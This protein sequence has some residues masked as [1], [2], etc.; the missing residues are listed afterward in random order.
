[1]GGSINWRHLLTFAL[2]VSCSAAP[3]NGQGLTVTSKS[4]PIYLAGNGAIFY[5]GPV[6]QTD[7]WY[8]WN[9]GVYADIWTSASFNQK[10]NFGKELDLTVGRVGKLGTFSYSANINYYVVIVTDVAGVNAELS[11]GFSRGAVSIEPYV[12]GEW[13]FPVRHGG[14]RRGVLGIGVYALP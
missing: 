8:Q 5:D 1:M 11:R 13:Y 14:P 3:A 4:K 2:L 9:N 7:A 6:Q 10:W 12:R